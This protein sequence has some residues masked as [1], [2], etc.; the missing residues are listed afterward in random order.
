MIY[1]TTGILRKGKMR[2]LEL[3]RRENQTKQRG[4]LEYLDGEQGTLTNYRLDLTR[5]RK[6]L[7]G[8]ISHV[9]H[10]PG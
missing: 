2:E 10:A 8:P 3:T 9:L 6:E 4:A 1:S 5:D 7:K